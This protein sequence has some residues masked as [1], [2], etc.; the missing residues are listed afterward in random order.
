MPGHKELNQVPIDNSSGVPTIVHLHKE[1][2]VYNEN[3][4]VDFSLDE[5]SNRMNKETKTNSDPS[6]PQSQPT[7]SIHSKH[8]FPI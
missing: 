6:E 3:H 7:L 1:F 2:F 8:K 5:C 4:N